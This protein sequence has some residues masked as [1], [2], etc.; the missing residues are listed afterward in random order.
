MPETRRILDALPNVDMAVLQSRIVDAWLD[1]VVA[2]SPGQAMPIDDRT[3]SIGGIVGR[4]IDT[5]YDAS[6]GIR[7]NHLLAAARRHGEFRRRQRCPLRTVT[8][9]IGLIP[10]AIETVMRRGGASHSTVR[11]VVDALQRDIRSAECAAYGG[12]LDWDKSH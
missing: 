7:R 3:G 4:L 10:G 11:A 9:G 6:D 12:F 1:S 5:R 2:R 8:E